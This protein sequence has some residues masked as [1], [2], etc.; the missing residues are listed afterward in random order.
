MLHF[1]N[2]ETVK[3]NVGYP[4]AFNIAIIGILVAVSILTARRRSG[5]ISF[6][7]MTQTTQIKGLA[8]LLVVV[9]HLWFHVSESRAVPILGDYSVTVFLILSGFGITNTFTKKQLEGFF[10]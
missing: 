6:M 1:A 8:I 2:Y 3:L 4:T 9:G 5:G 10:S 7:D